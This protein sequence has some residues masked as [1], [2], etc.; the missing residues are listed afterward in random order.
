MYVT[1]SSSFLGPL[2]VALLTNHTGQVSTSLSPFP[3]FPIHPIMRFDD[4]RRK[5]IRDGFWLIGL[6]MLLAFPILWFIS[7]KIGGEDAEM[8]FCVEEQISNPE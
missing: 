6:M 3:F 7:M 8:Y 1:R 5:Q 2:L 4:R